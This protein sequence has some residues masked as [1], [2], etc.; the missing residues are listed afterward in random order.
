MVIVVSFL[1]CMAP[2]DAPRGTNPEVARAEEPHP[3]PRLALEGGPLGP[4]RWASEEAVGECRTYGDGGQLLSWTTIT[5][6][7]LPLARQTTSGTRFT[8]T[9]RYR[10]D[11]TLAETWVY[12]RLAEESQELLV[13]EV[14][15]ESGRLVSRKSGDEETWEYDAAGRLTRQV[16]TTRIQRKTWGWRYDAE[17][18][19]AKRTYRSEWDSSV[20]REEV[21]AWEAGRLVETRVRHDDSW[22]T[23]TWTA[24]ISSGAP[25]HGD[26]SLSNSSGYRKY[27]TETWVHDADGRPLTWTYDEALLGR[28]T[29]K[30]DQLV[31]Q[32]LRG[33]D[34]EWDWDD[35]GRLVYHFDGS[36][37][38]TWSWG[39]DGDV[40]GTTWRDQAYTYEGDCPASLF[41]RPEVPTPGPVPVEPKPPRPYGG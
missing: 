32:E 33:H 37:V 25:E 4:R 39:D 13:H 35:A 26:F 10:T 14:H 27:G 40:A 17:A 6:A 8:W 5:A 31:R 20:D 36:N 22:S 34:Q 19:I 28:W 18:R 38:W 3:D 16:L 7:G 12:R 24:W 41:D 9:R 30:Q 2:T 21:Y 29:W 1:A 23:T 11:G 15:D